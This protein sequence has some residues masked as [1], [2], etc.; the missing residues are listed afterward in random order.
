MFDL[1]QLSLSTSMKLFCRAGSCVFVSD[2]VNLSSAFLTRQMAH[3]EVAMLVLDCTVLGF[4]SSLKRVAYLGFTSLNFGA[5]HISSFLSLRLWACLDFLM[6][7]YNVAIVG[8]PL[9][10]RSLAHLDVAAAVSSIS[11]SGSAT[12]TLDL[13]DLD[14]PMSLRS[15]A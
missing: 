6:L 4:A 2:Y 7:A 14:S 5:V 10:L 13:V 3:S 12:L 9:T 11:C 1:L 15:Y 8:F